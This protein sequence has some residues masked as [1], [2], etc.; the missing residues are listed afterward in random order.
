METN[1]STGIQQMVI[2]DNTAQC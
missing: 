2:R 1:G